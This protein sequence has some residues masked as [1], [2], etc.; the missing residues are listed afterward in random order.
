MAG[1]VLGAVFALMCSTA[2]DRLGGRINTPCQL[3]DLGG[4]NIQ[5]VF[6]GLC[7]DKLEHGTAISLK[8]GKKHVLEN[9]HWRM[10]FVDFPS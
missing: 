1:Q 9:M 6:S 7:R 5:P 8:Y 3:R 4:I 2:T 10:T